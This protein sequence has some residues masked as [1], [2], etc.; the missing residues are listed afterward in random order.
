VRQFWERTQRRGA[1]QRGVAGGG[2][3]SKGGEWGQEEQGGRWKPKTAA[4]VV[5]GRESAAVAVE[6]SSGRSG[7]G[8]KVGGT[9][10]E[11]VKTSRGSTVNKIF[12]VF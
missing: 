11:F 6:Q 1:R 9:F 8:R 3:A 5:G 7:G 10:L 4:R 12:P 2:R